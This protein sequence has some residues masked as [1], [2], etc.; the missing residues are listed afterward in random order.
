M[1]IHE[2]GFKLNASWSLNFLFC[3]LNFLF[4]KRWPNQQRSVNE[5]RWIL[6]VIHKTTKLLTTGHSRSSTNTWQENHGNTH[7]AQYNTDSQTHMMVL[8]PL[9][10][11]PAFEVGTTFRHTLKKWIRW[12]VLTTHDFELPK[13]AWMKFFLIRLACIH[14]CGDL[15]GLLT[16]IGRQPIMGGTIPQAG[17]LNHVR[18][19]KAKH[20]QAGSMSVSFLSDLNKR[21]DGL[22]YWSNESC[23]T[24]PQWWTISWNYEPNNPFPP[25]CCF[26]SGHNNIHIIA[27]DMKLEC[28]EW[29]TD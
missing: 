3:I 12:F 26:W 9:I 4:C 25:H 5:K 15:L 17:V 6:H 14:I 28:G 23:L 24:S 20:R 18:W 16:G 11:I 10:L 19:D 13:K 7:N 8:F 21:C 27:I 2:V 29:K 22:S 1:R